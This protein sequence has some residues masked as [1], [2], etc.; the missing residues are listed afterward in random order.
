MAAALANNSVAG[1]EPE[2]ASVAFV[3]G[4]KKGLEQM[5]FDLVGHAT[6]VVRHADPD[7]F[8]CGNCVG[9]ALVLVFSFRFDRD[10]CCFECQR[11]AL[12]HRV[13]S[14]HH[15]IQNDLSQLSRVDFGVHP[16]FASVQIAF[17]RNV[18]AEET[19][20]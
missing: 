17:Y 14:V 3:L 8:S 19:Q 7:I 16:V 13:T 2:P 10:G 6:A 9:G 1:R 18:F 11:S 5:L 12:G 20:K 4:R 15:Q